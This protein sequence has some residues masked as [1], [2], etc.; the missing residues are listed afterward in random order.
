MR[1]FRRAVTAR[2][3]LAVTALAAAGLLLAAL[4][5]CT[6]ADASDLASA[7]GDTGNSDDQPAPTSTLDPQ[8]AALKFVQCM[9]DHGVDMA[10]PEFSGDGG[11]SIQ[12]GGEGVDP[13]TVD[14]A[15]E[16]CREYAPFNSGSGPAPDP[17]MEEKMRQ[18]AQCMRDNGVPNFPDPDGGAVRIDDTIAG[19]P[20]FP[21]AQE[22]CQAQF[23][24]DMPGPQTRGDGPGSTGPGG[25]G[26]GPG[27]G[28]IVGGGPAGGR[29]T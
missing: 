4:T 28:T 9:R 13:S 29:T 20:D 27:G 3:P 10:D 19:D 23:L 7:T 15:M 16:A 17:E 2:F 8:E 26:A 12:I 21:A 24:P 18:F 11:M 22:K 1:T 14:A 6:P 5:A 25:G